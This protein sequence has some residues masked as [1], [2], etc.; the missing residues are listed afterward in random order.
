VQL[1]LILLILSLWIVFNALNFI[2]AFVNFYMAAAAHAHAVFDTGC[3]AICPM[4]DVMN[5]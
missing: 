2:A 3:A 4:L 5:L 1:T